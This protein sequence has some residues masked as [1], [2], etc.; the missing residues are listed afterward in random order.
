MT[1]DGARPASSSRP[2]VEIAGVSK[3]FAPRGQG[4]RPVEALADIDLSLAAGE[5][6]SLIGPSGCGKSTLLRIVGDLTT[7]TAGAVTVNGKPAEQARRDRDYGMVFQAP[8]LFD[9]RS[10][11]GNVELAKLLGWAGDPPPVVG[12]GWRPER[13]RAPWSFTRT[14]SDRHRVYLFRTTPMAR[15]NR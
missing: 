8:I 5:F 6:V 12:A 13:L 11:Q 14:A 1:M 2:V 4:T 10:V 9:W 15:W 7:P 3:V